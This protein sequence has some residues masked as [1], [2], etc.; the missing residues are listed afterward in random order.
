M[1]APEQLV[2]GSKFARQFDAAGSAVLGHYVAFARSTAQSSLAKT[3]GP[4]ASVTQVRNLPVYCCAPHAICVHIIWKVWF[5]S[6]KT[7]HCTDLFYDA[8]FNT[9]ILCCHVLIASRFYKSTFL[10]E[11]RIQSSFTHQFSVQVYNLMDCEW[12]QFNLLWV[13]HVTSHSCRHYLC[14]SLLLFI[15]WGMASQSFSFEFCRVLKHRKIQL[16]FSQTQ[17]QSSFVG[18]WLSHGWFV[19]VMILQAFPGGNGS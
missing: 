14:P 3:P 16:G 7:V 9:E 18:V 4:H 15:I 17:I 6:L 1:A 5:F 12:V 10:Y 2:I 19:S 13:S 11:S 8:Y